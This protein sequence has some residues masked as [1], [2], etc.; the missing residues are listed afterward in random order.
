M[1]A[2][3][4]TFNSRSTLSPGVRWIAGWGAIALLCNFFQHA[5]C[6]L[7]IGDEDRLVRV[8]MV[9]GVMAPIAFSSLVVLGAGAMML[10]L[11]LA[12]RG[13]SRRGL[14]RWIEELVE[15]SRRRPSSVE[16]IATV[17]AFV[18]LQVCFGAVWREPLRGIGC[19]ICTLVTFVRVRM[20]IGRI[21]RGS[22]IRAHGG[23]TP[24]G[25]DEAKF[26]AAKNSPYAPRAPSE[27]DP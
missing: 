11:N 1:S 4:A 16:T 6:K 10:L 24:G 26:P 22:A 18:A 9:A 5:W 19:I 23:D 12:L 3:H 25:H 17:G 20:W 15:L 27:L 8:T 13:T 2:S 14:V 21:G 7:P